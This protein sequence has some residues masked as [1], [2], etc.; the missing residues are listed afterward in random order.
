MRNS[1][2]KIERVHNDFSEVL[3]KMWN[4]N[5]RQISKVNLT[6]NIANQLRQNNQKRPRYI[7]NYWPISK[8][9]VKVY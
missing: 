7:V 9:K 1:S 4:D 2:S 5:G 6:K 8:R 3:N